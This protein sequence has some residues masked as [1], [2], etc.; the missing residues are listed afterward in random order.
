MRPRSKSRPPRHKP[1]P[2]TA[3]SL[4]QPHPN[5]PGD[6]NSSFRPEYL[7][8]PQCLGIYKSVEVLSGINGDAWPDSCF[9][10]A[11]Q[12]SSLTTVYWVCFSSFLRTRY[13][14]VQGSIRQMER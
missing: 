9:L 13:G 3:C 6:R 14:C 1:H 11:S 12:G 10:I 8:K 2:E 7:T 4:L 5:S